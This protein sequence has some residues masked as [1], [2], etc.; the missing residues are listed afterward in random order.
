[1]KGLLWQVIDK[2]KYEQTRQR[3]PKAMPQIHETVLKTVSSFQNQNSE[4]LAANGTS[5]ATLMRLSQKKTGTR[6][7]PF[8]MVR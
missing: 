1:M 7:C 8:F 2:M 4:Q 3:L 5:N 6:R